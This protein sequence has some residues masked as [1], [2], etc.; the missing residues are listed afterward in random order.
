ME[1]RV[2]PAIFY[3]PP[4]I[5]YTLIVLE[6]FAAYNPF[7]RSSLPLW[8]EEFT[9]ARK[10]LPLSYLDTFRWRS[11]G[12]CGFTLG[13]SVCMQKICTIIG[14]EPCTTSCLMVCRKTDPNVQLLILVH[15]VLAHST[16]SFIISHSCCVQLLKACARP[17]F[18]SVCKRCR[19]IKKENI[20]Y[21][22]IIQY[23]FII[24]NDR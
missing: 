23:S 8:R 20:Q 5:H 13:S 10:K 17:L 24:L 3:N 14:S 4:T 9:F 15:T 2:T 19:L 6:I 7:A 1:Q 21:S 12:V 16:R 22:Y 18:S 11:T